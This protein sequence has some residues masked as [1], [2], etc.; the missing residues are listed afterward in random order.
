MR[1]GT[2]P[3]GLISRDSSVDKVL[4]DGGIGIR[5]PAWMRNRGSPDK[6]WGPL[7]LSYNGYRRCVP[8]GKAAADHS[9]PPSVEINNDGITFPLPHRPSWSF[10]SLIKKKKGYTVCYSIW[11]V[12]TLCLIFLWMSIHFQVNSSS[13]CSYS[14]CDHQSIILPL[15]YATSQL[16]GVPV[17]SLSRSVRPHGA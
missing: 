11:C 2:C 4:D 5:F 7:S 17:R 14:S 9:P 12:L 10:A 8:G 1:F 16:C 13:Y 15:S 6:L 3:T